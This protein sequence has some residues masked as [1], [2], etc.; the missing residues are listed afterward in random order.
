MVRK[1]KKK[2]KEIND[3]NE[4]S[5]DDFD[6]NKFNINKPLKSDL[7]ETYECGQGNKIE[8]LTERFEI[9]L[10]KLEKEILDGLKAE[11]INISYELRKSILKLNKSFSRNKI[12]P[13]Y[14]KFEEEYL[15][16]IEDLKEK[17]REYK[18]IKKLRGATQEEAQHLVNERYLLKYEI[19]NL[20]QRA[21]HLENYLNKYKFLF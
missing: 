18:K 4:E 8:K 15:I 20:V 10:T 17:K 1:I 19:I 11:G 21:T 16:L 5:F 12:E 2:V 14:I 6:L 13:D 7:V 3:I 9:R